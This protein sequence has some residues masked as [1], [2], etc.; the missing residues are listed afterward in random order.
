[1]EPVSIKG[2]A[3]IASVARVALLSSQL[4][5]KHHLRHFE[6]MIQLPNGQRAVAAFMVTGPFNDPRSAE[7]IRAMAESVSQTLVGRP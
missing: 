1:V 4:A 3:E 7:L 5:R 2:D 6:Q